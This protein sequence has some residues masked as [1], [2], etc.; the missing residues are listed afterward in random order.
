MIFKRKKKVCYVSCIYLLLEVGFKTYK[1]YQEYS[2]IMS[3]CLFS[4]G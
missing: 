3:L 2:K 1:T 4:P